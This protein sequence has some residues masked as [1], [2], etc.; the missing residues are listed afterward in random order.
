MYVECMADRGWEVEDVTGDGGFSP[1]E[2]P[3]EQVDELND[4]TFA[5][6]AEADVRPEYFTQS[7]WEAWHTGLMETTRCLEAEGYSISDPPSLQQFIDSQGEWT[8][9]G[10]LLQS[11]AIQ[12]FDLPALQEVC[13]EEAFWPGPR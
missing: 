3:N 2:I 10:A 9:Y 11:G 13:P 8:P 7:E 12:G 5:C 6:W 4:A 1:G